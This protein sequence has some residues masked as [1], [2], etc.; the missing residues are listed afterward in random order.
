NVAVHGRLALVGLV[1]LLSE[2]GCARVDSKLPGRGEKAGD[3]QS[4]RYH[5]MR[6]SPGADLR[7][8][9]EA[10]ASQHKVHAGSIVTCVGSLSQ[11]GLRLAGK[12]E[13]RLWKKDFEI[14]SLVGTVG[15]GGVHLHISVADDAG[16]ALGGHVV[17]GC[18]VRTTAEIVLAQ[19]D[20]LSFDRAIDPATGYR[21]LTIRP[22]GR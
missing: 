11:A 20:D 13:S 18:I 5:V 16:N 10:Y 22:R 12:S 4:A 17:D 19:F 6:L 1:F 3:A 15:D 14:T 21:E 8:E 9:I 2:V 7:K